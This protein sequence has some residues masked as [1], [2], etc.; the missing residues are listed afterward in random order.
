MANSFIIPDSAYDGFDALIRIDGDNLVRVAEHIKKE[1]LTLDLPNFVGTVA[2]ATGVAADDLEEALDGAL[3][4]LSG[5][6]AEF[7]MPAGEFV[8][9]LTHLIADQNLE[10]YEP[11]Q[12]AWERVAPAVTSFLEPNGFVTQ[13]NKAYRL[14]VNRP[15]LVDAVRLFTEMRPVYD[16]EVTAIKAYVI[17]STMSVSYNEFGDQRRV[18][19]TFDKKDLE[20]LQEQVDRALRKIELLEKQVALLEVP[21]LVAGTDRN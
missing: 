4:P 15:A 7:R 19:L 3:I 9:F 13:L 18:H 8:E 21:S 16:D 20:R 2:K 14:L 10:W 12:S 1:K 5:L 6:R 11:N 17:T